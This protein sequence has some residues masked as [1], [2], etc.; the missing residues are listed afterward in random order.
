LQKERKESQKNGIVITIYQ[1]H[2]DDDDD[3]DA[4]YAHSQFHIFNLNTAQIS[5]FLW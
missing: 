2:D 1:Q 5:L 3:G 4:K